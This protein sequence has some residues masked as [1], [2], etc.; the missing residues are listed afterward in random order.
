MLCTKHKKMV[1]IMHSFSQFLYTL[2]R[3]SVNKFLFLL[4]VC[5]SMH[6]FGADLLAPEG[7][8]SHMYEN[9]TDLLPL[10]LPLPPYPW[11]Q[12]TTERYLQ[13][14]DASCWSHSPALPIPTAM[15]FSIP[16]CINTTMARMQNYG[17]TCSCY[18][19]TLACASCTLCALS[20][21]TIA[22]ECC[23]T[24]SPMIMHAAEYAIYPSAVI[25]FLSGFIGGVPSRSGHLWGNGYDR[26]MM[27]AAIYFFN[28]H[29]LQANRRQLL[30]A[31]SVAHMDITRQVVDQ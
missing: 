11:D 17:I 28:Q 7:A 30:A 10:P 23:C 1:K 13:H 18:C 26:T 25:G 24:V 31:P 16:C 4:I 21:A 29:A 20:A 12:E 5:S 8:S 9:S 19:Q 3:V 22:G 2:Q 14:Y 6:I 15:P 27:R